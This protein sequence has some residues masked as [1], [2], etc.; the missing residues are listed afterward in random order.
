M[1]IET[2]IEHLREQADAAV[3]ELQEFVRIPSI[4]AQPERHDDV[5]RAAQ[6]LMA[7]LE[8]AGLEHVRLV[9]TD[10]L[11]AV[12]GDWL[13]AGDAPTVL[14]YGH[15]DIQPAD[16]DWSRPPFEA[17]VEEGR[18]WGRGT[19]DDKGQ[20]LCHVRAI[21][22]WMRAG[23]P[24]VNVKVVF[25][26]EEEM[27]S[28]HFEQVI[29]RADLSA[30]VLVVSDSPMRGEGRPAITY[31]LRG[32]CSLEVDVEGPNDDLHSGSFGGTVWNPIEALCHMVS[33]C[34]DPVTGRIVIPGF[35]DDVVE[36]GAD[37][38]QALQAVAESPE[39]VMAAAGVDAL[40]GEEGFAP[41]E[42]TGL[43]PS[44]ELNGI[45]GG[46]QGDGAKTIV[47][48]SAHAKI[49][50]RLVANQDPDTIAALVAKHL[51]SLAQPGTRVTVRH[52]GEGYPVRSPPD[53]P[54]VQ[55]VGKA[56]EEAF[57]HPTVHI[58]EGGSIPAVAMMQKRLGVVPVLAGFG[59][60]DER[61]HGVG[62][63]F[64]LRSYH[65]GSEAAARMLHRIADAVHGSG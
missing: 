29:D 65:Q 41:A 53:H 5:R 16:G 55:A 3:A 61:M 40:W 34:K 21:E 51:E 30:D 64:R 2:A 57:G 22:A 47:P 1:A 58:P 18:I 28:T 19:T 4:G 42:R 9:E 33:A 44:F 17:V 63:S 43:R 38:R 25:E 46:Y 7:R 36:P 24:P 59:H 11:P 48:R 54:M 62:E 35:Y 12:V 31:S 27:G 50:C 13:H 49:S 37:E 60:R 8:R 20:L 32:L 56:W 6:W 26:G 45:W 39:E 23:G 52:R 14:V 15:Y 10:G